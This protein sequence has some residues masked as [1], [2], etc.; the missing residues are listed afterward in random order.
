MEFSLSEAG[1]GGRVGA[2]GRSG[3]VVGMVVA[4]GRRDRV[5]TAVGFSVETCCV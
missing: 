2:T 3:K 4:A 1:M 5:R